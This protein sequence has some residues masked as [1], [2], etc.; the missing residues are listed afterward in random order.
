MHSNSLGRRITVHS[1][2]TPVGHFIGT[3]DDLT[4]LKECE[5]VLRD[6]GIQ[7]KDR[8]L[9]E[10]IRDQ[11]KAFAT[12][13]LEMAKKIE[14][15]R[16]RSGSYVGPFMVN[17]AFALELFLKSLAQR[18]EK[19]LRGHSLLMLFDE[20]PPEA[21]GAVDHVFSNAPNEL[22]SFDGSGDLRG[23]FVNLDDA[24]ISWRYSY[25]GRSEG[26]FYGAKA[27]LLLLAVLDLA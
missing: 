5:R 10:R 16:G 9:D 4:D 8:P 13:T 18:Y 27:I 6:A 15:L 20:L 19:T 26:R 12:V 11:A 7:R 21:R 2:N 1:G 23:L 22:T 25:E 17:A 14:K 24:F 3:G